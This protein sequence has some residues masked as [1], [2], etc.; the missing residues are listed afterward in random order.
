MNGTMLIISPSGSI[1]T[2]P[3][4]AAPDL[5]KL[6]EEVGGYIEA[7]SLFDRITYRGTTYPCAAFCNEE[8]KLKG[9]E[10]NQRATMV[11]LAALAAHKIPPE[12]VDDVL[13][14]K[15]LVIFGDRELMD[16]L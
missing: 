16:A 12:K 3:L 6:Q 13:C 4:Y 15:V 14:G 7:I 11:W 2:V 10:P 8:G 9:M 5:E 1:K